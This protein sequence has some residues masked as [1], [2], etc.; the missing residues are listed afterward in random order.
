MI[1]HLSFQPFPGLMS[2]HAQTIFGGLSQAGTPPPSET[3]TVPVDDNDALSCDLSTPPS[4]QADHKTVIMIHGLSGSHVSNYMVRISRKLYQ[5]GYRTVRV[6]LRACGSGSHLAS[7][8]YHGGTSPDILQVIKN[9]KVKTPD[10]P[11]ILMGFSLGG[12]IALKLA[13]ELQEKASDLI[14][15]TIAVCPPIDLAHSL[16]ILSQPFNRFYHK[17]YLDNIKY[18]TMKWVGNQSIRSIYEFDNAV[19]APLWGFKNA[20]DYHRQCSSCYLLPKIRHSCYILFAADDP[21]VDYRRALD[22]PLSR[23]VKIGLSQYGGHL[24]FL[25]QMG[26]GRQFFWLDQLLQEWIETKE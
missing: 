21:F 15:R 3:F 17:Y 1:E 18:Q 12:N 4:W 25:G 26:K 19:T 16:T 9:L 6:N 22:H 13:G 2:P 11:I 24:G 8:P 14:Y 23:S 10:S 5:A 20:S 7:R